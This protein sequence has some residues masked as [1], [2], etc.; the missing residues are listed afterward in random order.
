LLDWLLRS[1]GWRK[2]G[3]GIRRLACHERCREMA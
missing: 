3:S 2:S 1:R